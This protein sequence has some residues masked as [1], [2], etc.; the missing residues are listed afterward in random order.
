M[1]LEGGLVGIF[2]LDIVYGLLIFGLVRLDFEK[3]YR[4]LY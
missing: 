1:G 4:L 3:V 2:L